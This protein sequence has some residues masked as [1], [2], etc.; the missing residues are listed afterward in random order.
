M[1]NFCHWTCTPNFPGL[2]DA[3]HF[4]VDIP[5]ETS[6]EDVKAK[7]ALVCGITPD[8]TDVLSFQEKWPRAIQQQFDSGDGTRWSWADLN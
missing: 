2:E 6:L 3:E 1:K 7:L 5:E 4:I 8:K